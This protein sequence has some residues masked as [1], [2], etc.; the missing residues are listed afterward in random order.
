M[1]QYILNVATTKLQHAVTDCKMFGQNYTESFS[2]FVQ[3][4]SEL[5]K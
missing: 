5:K 3:F 1:R 2:D 4:K